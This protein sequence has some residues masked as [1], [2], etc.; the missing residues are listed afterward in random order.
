MVDGVVR[1]RLRAVGAGLAQLQAQRDHRAELRELDLLASAA[2]LPGLPPLGCTA[3]A[4]G[5]V[6]RSR[7]DYECLGVDF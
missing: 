2:A 5:A 3:A 1:E 4:R 7:V 6:E